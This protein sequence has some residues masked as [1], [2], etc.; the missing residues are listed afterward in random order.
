ML[1]EVLAG[2]TYEAIVPAF[3]EQ[4]KKKVDIIIKNRGKQ[5]FFRVIFLDLVL[6]PCG[7][8]KV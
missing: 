3:L 8:K 4:L 2:V 6:R 7:Q 1:T 5:H